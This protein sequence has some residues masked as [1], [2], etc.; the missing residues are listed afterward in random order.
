MAAF[1]LRGLGQCLRS[2]YQMVVLEPWRQTDPR[3]RDRDLGAGLLW[4]LILWLAGPQTWVGDKG[5][6]QVGGELLGTELGVSMVS[7][8]CFTN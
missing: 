1:R 7:S 2:A 5:S 4:F 8:W 3:H 6:E